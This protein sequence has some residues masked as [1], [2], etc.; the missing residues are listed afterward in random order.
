[1]DVVSRLLKDRILLLGSQGE[2]GG[3]GGGGFHLKIRVAL[4]TR[5]A[6]ETNVASQKR[7]AYETVS[8]LSTLLRRGC[9]ERFAF[10]AIVANLPIAPF[11]F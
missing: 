7:D 10:G 8:W 1:M 11:A 2:L 3:G 9:Y 6:Y 5:V 4:E